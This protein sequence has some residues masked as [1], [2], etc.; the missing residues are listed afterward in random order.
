MARF[1]QVCIFVIRFFWSLA[2]SAGRGVRCQ[3]VEFPRGLGGKTF[4]IRL[5]GQQR[6]KERFTCCFRTFFLINGP[7]TAL[8]FPTIGTVSNY[9]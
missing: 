5:L 3:T 7:K 4:I 1:S 6:Y 9:N 8:S 2:I